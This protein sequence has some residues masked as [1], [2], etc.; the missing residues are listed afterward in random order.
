M[1]YGLNDKGERIY[2]KDSIKGEKYYCPCCKGEMIR[3]VGKVKSHHFAH[4]SAVC[5]TW[6]SENKGSWHRNLQ[7]CFSPDSQEVLVKSDNSEVYHISDVFL[8]GKERNTII[9]F[10]HSPM[11]IQEFTKRNDFYINNGTTGI[12][13]N[14]IVWVFDCRNKEI[15]ITLSRVLGAYNGFYWWK[16]ENRVG[17]ENYARMTWNNAIKTYS[18]IVV[19]MNKDITIFLCVNQRGFYK[20]YKSGEYYTAD[21]DYKCYIKEKNVFIDNGSDD[22]FFVRL[23]YSKQGNKFCGGG[24]LSLENFVKYMKNVDKYEKSLFN[25]RVEKEEKDREQMNKLLENLNLFSIHNKENFV[26]FGDF[27]FKDNLSNLISYE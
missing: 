23:D 4:I 9:E 16:K 6:Y 13:K 24:I 14:R 18:N 20:D 8:K 17:F 7:N 5:D 12:E 22:M 10:Q 3:K 11:S 26:N 21:G 27:S 1:F 15:F 2:I 25:Y 19:D